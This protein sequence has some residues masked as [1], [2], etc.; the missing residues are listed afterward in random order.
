MFWILNLDETAQQSV[1]SYA[2]GYFIV[3]GIL[4]YGVFRFRL[5]SDKT[6]TYQSGEEG[7]LSDNGVVDILKDKENVLWIG[8]N[9]NLNKLDDISNTFQYFP[10]GYTSKNL[11]VKKLLNDRENNIWFSTGNGIYRLNAGQSSIVHYTVENGLHSDEFVN[12]SGT[13]TSANLS[14]H[15][16]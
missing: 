14:T 9:R 7:S 5:D 1:L 15:P 8:T 2:L 4:G 11:V 16:L 10:Q 3:A 6:L 12:K 13:A